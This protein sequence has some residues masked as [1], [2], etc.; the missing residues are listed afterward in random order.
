MFRYFAFYVKILFCGVFL[1][2]ELCMTER[3]QFPDFDNAPPIFREY[4]LEMPKNQQLTVLDRNECQSQ[5]KH[6]ARALC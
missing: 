6:R 5:E 3:H 1:S 4:F 2:R